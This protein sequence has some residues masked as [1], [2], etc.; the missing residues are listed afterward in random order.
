MIFTNR[1]Q[2]HNAHRLATCRAAE[3]NQLPTRPGDHSPDSDLGHSYRPPRGAIPLL[4]NY[5][6]VHSHGPNAIPLPYQP[7][8]YLGE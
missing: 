3:R 1:D 7:A 6:P 5:L 2:I 4:T 8:C